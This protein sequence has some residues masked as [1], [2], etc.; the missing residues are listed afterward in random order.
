MQLIKPIVPGFITLFILS[1]HQQPHPP[2][3]LSLPED[4]ADPRIEAS[5]PAQLQQ[6]QL[7]AL[8]KMTQ[9]FSVTGRQLI[10][11]KKGIRIYIDPAQ[12]ETEKGQPVEG[13]VAVT[14]IELTNTQEL[15][16]AGAATM[17]NG[18]LLVSGGSYYI[19]LKNQH[20]SLRIKPGHHLN[21]QFPRLTNESMELFYGAPN[22]D[23]IMNWTPTS[24][25]LDFQPLTINR[26]SVAARYAVKFNYQPDLSGQFIYDSTSQRAIYVH[27][28]LTFEQLIAELHKQG[29]EA[30]IDTLKYYYRRY[31]R[32]IAG[33]VVDSTPLI[34]CFRYRLITPQLREKENRERDSVCMVNEELEERFQKTATEEEKR[35]RYMQEQLNK[36][37]QN[38]GI[39]QLGWINCDRFFQAPERNDLPIELPITQTA[40][41]RIDYFIVFRN[42]NS[43]YQGVT[44]LKDST[45]FKIYQLPTGQPF[46][47][48]AYVQDAAGRLTEFRASGTVQQNALKLKLH[49]SDG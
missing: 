41:S 23:G 19:G 13:A 35:I 48:L 37:Y 12:L 8:N 6:M 28:T 38:S 11:G 32:N 15:L 24:T 16:Q 10:T 31:K 27:R 34:P 17:S 18:Q 7:A 42:M 2:A 44:V 33:A 4:A 29:I 45:G 40:G 49:K 3:V 9:H 39:T 1:C 22:N 21:I 26:S 5:Q 25:T 43:L 47:L 46:T 14:L 20:Q 36:Y 30:S